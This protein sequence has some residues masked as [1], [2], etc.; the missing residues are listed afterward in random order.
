MNNWVLSPTYLPTARVAT[1]S[2]SGNPTFML[3]RDRGG[4]MQDMLSTALTIDS[5]EVDSKDA[6]AAAVV[7]T[8][9]SHNVLQT[10]DLI[11]ADVDGAG[12]GTKGPSVDAFVHPA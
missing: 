1:T 5:G 4:T 2:S 10:G 7:D 8:A 3:R 6:T 9:S 12:T 11:W